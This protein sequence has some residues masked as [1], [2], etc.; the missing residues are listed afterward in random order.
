MRKYNKYV[1]VTIEEL[2]S[3]GKW[4]IR[5]AFI[6]ENAEVRAGSMERSVLIVKARRVM[7]AW[8]YNYPHHNSQ[9]RISNGGR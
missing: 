3:D 5:N 7:T 8:I 2:Q 1:P 9:L 4:N 6:S